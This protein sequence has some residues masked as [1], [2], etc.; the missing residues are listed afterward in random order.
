MSRNKLPATSDK[1]V[2]ASSDGEIFNEFEPYN[3]IEETTE[4]AEEVANDSYGTTMLDGMI[5]Y[6]LVPVRVYRKPTESP[7]VEI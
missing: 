2:W 6:K 4:N 5:I 7:W 1:Y 3:S